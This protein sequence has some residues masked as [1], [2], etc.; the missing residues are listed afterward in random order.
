MSIPQQRMRAA[1][2]KKN[3]G[4]VMS[5]GDGTNLY[6]VP[7][8]GKS[9]VKLTDNA[10]SFNPN[11]GLGSSG[12]GGKRTEKQEFALALQKEAEA[13]GKPINDA[14]AMRR[15]ARE[16]K[17]NPAGVATRILG[18]NILYATESDPDKRRTMED[19]ALGMAMRMARE[20]AGGQADSPGLGSLPPATASKI[21][22]LF[23]K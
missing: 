13:Q 2:E 21:D 17:N 10:K 11:T 19:Q 4:K 15:A 5:V 23:P 1:Y 8:S 3:P 12:R 7:A 20:S 6:S 16:L 14:E 18:N 9:A 22:A